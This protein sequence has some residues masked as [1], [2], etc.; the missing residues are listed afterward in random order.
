MEEKY[1]HL[2]GSG[3][4]AQALEKEKSRRKRSIWIVVASV[5]GILVL[6]A[7]AVIAWYFST[8]KNNGSN[9]SGGNPGKSGDST[10]NNTPNDGSD[11]SIF[12]LDSRLHKSFYGMAYTPEGSQLPN[13]GNSLEN[14]I[15]DIQILSQLT[16]RVRLYGADC[17][18]SALVLEAIKQTKVDMQV[19]LGNY[20]IPDDNTPYERQRDIIKE[21][22]QTYGADHVAGVTVGNEFMLNYL[23]G[24][25]VQDPNGIIGQ[26]GAAILKANIEDTRQMIDGLQLSKHIPVGNSD[27]GSFF[28][29]SV[30]TDVEYGMSNVHAWF[31]NTTAEGAAPWVFQFFDENNVQPAALLP[32]KPKMYIAETGWP[33]KSSDAG[34]ANNGGSD[35]SVPNL[36]VFIDNFVCQANSNNVG[37]FFFEYFD[38][39]WKDAMFGGVEGWWGLFNADRTLKD[40]TIPDCPAP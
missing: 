35:A 32:N 11:P 20:P 18:Q 40:I 9:G 36:Q 38:E 10:G 26:Q 12:E 34:N 39:Q 15:K 24:Q 1:Q 13:C 17:N 30:L 33:T 37:Y 8:H 23:T 25:G 31:A 4:M 29:N 14:V 27:A 6:V 7:V 2:E 16:T 3:G 22:L 28:S 19:F 21:A 5:V